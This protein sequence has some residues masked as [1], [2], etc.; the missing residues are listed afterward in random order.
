MKNGKRGIKPFFDRAMI[1]LLTFGEYRLFER[2]PEVGFSEEELNKLKTREWSEPEWD[3][4]ASQPR[5]LT[6]SGK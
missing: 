4:I 5:P 6:D 2:A 3:F 1:I